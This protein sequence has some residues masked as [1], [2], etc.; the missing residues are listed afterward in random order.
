MGYLVETDST[1]FI[2]HHDVLLFLVQSTLY[3]PGDLVGRFDTF[4]T[5]ALKDLQSGKSKIMDGKN[6]ETIRGA[7]LAKFKTPN[8]NVGSVTSL[9]RT[10]LSNYDADWSA[11][12][13][14]KKIIEELTH[15]DVVAVAKKILG[16]ANK[17]KMTIGYTPKDVKADDFPKEYVAFDPK[18]NNKFAAKPKFACAVDVPTL[19]KTIDETKGTGSSDADKA[20]STEGDDKDASVHADKTA[21]VK[22]EEEVQIPAEPETEAVEPVSA[23]EFESDSAQT[24]GALMAALKIASK[25]VEEDK[26][27]VHYYPAGSK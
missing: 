19:A 27:K 22:P 8:Q 12:S 10:L 15:A 5:K 13:K 3:K 24:Q 7:K 20:V 2:S 1:V 21:P 23:E 26:P 25:N 9:M 17:K 16:A 11:M 14:K 6:F 4:I 18:K